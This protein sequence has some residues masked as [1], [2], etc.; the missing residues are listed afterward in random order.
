MAGG[1]VHGL[2]VGASG[3]VFFASNRTQQH[4]VNK[5][6]PNTSRNAEQTVDKVKPYMLRD[7]TALMTNDELCSMMNER[8]FMFCGSGAE[9]QPRRDI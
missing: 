8:S 3:M 5:P 7:R 1:G 9:R 6:S 2:S 4:T